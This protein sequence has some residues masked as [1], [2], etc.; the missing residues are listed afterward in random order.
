MEPG[1]VITTARCETG[2][3]SG[4]EHTHCSLEHGQPRLSTILEAVATY[5]DSDPKTPAFFKATKQK[6]NEYLIT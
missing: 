6:G 1:S 3:H 2:S 4:Q 5:R